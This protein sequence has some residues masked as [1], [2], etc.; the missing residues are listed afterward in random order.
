LRLPVR[1]EAG[2]EDFLAGGD[3]N[4][5]FEETIGDKLAMSQLL[6][7]LR[8]KPTSTGEIAETL[9]L[10][11]SEISRHINSPSI[12]KDQSDRAHHPV[13]MVGFLGLGQPGNS[14]I[15]LLVDIG[16]PVKKHARAGVVKILI[17]AFDAAKGFFVL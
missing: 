12:F 2:I 10:N 5:L 3:L 7:L 16:V 1:S 6:S 15:T 14:H 4:K 13:R 8:E 11:P 9:G 17:Q